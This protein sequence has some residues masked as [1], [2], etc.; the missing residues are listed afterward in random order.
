MV[1]N[2]TFIYKINLGKIYISKSVDILKSDNIG[3]IDKLSEKG[4]PGF[5]SRTTWK[6]ILASL[7]YLLIIFIIFSLIIAATVDLPEDDTANESSNDQTEETLPQVEF[8]AEITL[9]G[10]DWLCNITT[11]EQIDPSNLKYDIVDSS[12]NTVKSDQQFPTD[13]FEDGD[14]NGIKWYDDNSDGK[15]NS[16]DQIGIYNPNDN[17]IGWEKGYKFVI[18]EGAQ[19]NVTLPGETQETN[20]APTASFS[21][22]PNEPTIQDDIQFTDDSTDSDGSIESWSWDFD[23]GTTSNNQNP[24]HSYSSTGDYTVELEVVDDEGASDTTTTTISVSEEQQTTGEV[25]ILDDNH[26]TDSVG[27]LHLIGEVKNNRDENVNYVKIT[28]TIYDG[29]TVV[30]SDF[31]YTSMDILTP[32]QKSPFEFMIEEPSS[33]TDYSLNVEYS[34]TY[35]SPYS[36]LQIQGESDHTDDYGYYYINGEVENTGSL[37]VDYVEVVVTLYDSNGNIIGTDFTYTDPDTLSGGEKA[38]F[39]FMI[40]HDE[41]PGSISSY[42][43]QVQCS[44]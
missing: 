28:A 32:N 23:D 8:D 15:L 30:D 19:G 12:G 40:D 20:N 29:S 13:Q 10:E 42:E 2:S 38:P 25:K 27:Y 35:S 1:H 26:Y 33:W 9:T 24:S 17:N 44:S 41:L 3:L 43:L 22:S 18:S 34:S 7:G 36:D 4:V 31:T 14:S 11:D 37:T 16:G 21:Y 39:E 5:R 6:M